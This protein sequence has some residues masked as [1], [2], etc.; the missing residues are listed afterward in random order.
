MKAALVSL[1]S[2]CVFTA[3][4]Q[5]APYETAPPLQASAILKPAYLVSPS[6][7][8][9]ES[10]TTRFGRNQYTVE[11]AWGYFTADGDPM[12]A[13]RVAEARALTELQNV[14][15]TAEFKSSLKTAAKTPLAA[16]ES[17]LQD[18]AKVVQ[19]TAQGVWK[20]INRAGESA[21]NVS[22]GRKRGS[23][24]DGGAK[25][26][27][28]LS[29][30]KRTLALQLGTD[31]YSTNPVFQEEL[32]KVAWAKVAG[33]GIFTLATLP[34][35][36]G[37]G[38]ALSATGASRN[39]QENLRD[40]A[41]ADLRLLNKKKLLTMGL[42]SEAAD[43]FLANPA[44]SPT[45]QTAFVEALHTLADVN[46][47]SVLVSLATQT[48]SS[49]IDAL[50]CSGIAQVFA[51]LH[52]EKIPLARLT[53]L[54]GLPV[55]IATD[56]RLVVALQWDT[57]YWNERTENFIDRLPSASSQATSAKT[58]APVIALTGTTTPRLREELEKRQITLLTHVLPGP[59][60]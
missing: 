13:A 10:V 20:F 9:L 32:E 57:A 28:G 52:A 17:V 1:V 43:R 18:P 40:F 30:Y 27:L 56:G 15:R 55:G 53:T 3:M 59:Q 50:F 2:L 44:F 23:G 19:G 11:T 6:H 22:Q 35:G 54:G 46:D 42:S 41:P 16:V 39:F 45:T 49:E 33:K 7:R 36:G 26:F 48:A 21:K 4:A 51:T 8:V 31:P 58:G 37:A 38:M 29:K 14:S 47:R 34:I 25:E 24:E 60:K 12:L 5:E